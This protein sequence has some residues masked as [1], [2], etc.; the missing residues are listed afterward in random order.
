MFTREFAE[1]IVKNELT[2]E[3]KTA[4]TRAEK[5]AKQIVKTLEQGGLYF[6]QQPVPPSGSNVAPTLSDQVRR[7]Q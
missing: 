2:N 6:A 4:K 3:F 7:A 5:M 1:K